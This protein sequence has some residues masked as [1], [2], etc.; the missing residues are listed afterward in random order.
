V[1]ILNG[2]QAIQ[3][4]VKQKQYAFHVAQPKGFM[5]KNRVEEDPNGRHL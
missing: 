3:S 4:K 1:A 2:F 5:N